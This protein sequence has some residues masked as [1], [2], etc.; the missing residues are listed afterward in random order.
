MQVGQDTSRI[1]ELPV[2]SL[3]S[4]QS[5][6]RSQPLLRLQSLL[7]RQKCEGHNA[8]RCCEHFSHEDLSGQEE[9]SST[10][11]TCSNNALQR[12]RTER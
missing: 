5:K 8:K 10:V 12:M 7:K 2:S 6:A 1:E 4:E 9:G 3:N 11:P